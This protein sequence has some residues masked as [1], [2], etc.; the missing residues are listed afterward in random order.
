MTSPLDYASIRERLQYWVDKFDALEIMTP[1]AEQMW[2]TAID[3]IKAL[4]P[5]SDVAE[6]QKIA[7]ELRKKFGKTVTPYTDWGSNV[8]LSSNNPIVHKAADMLERLQSWNASMHRENHKLLDDKLWA[9]SRVKSAEAKV[10]LLTEKLE[11]TEGA[12]RD[13][14]FHH[15]AWD[16][17]DFTDCY[18]EHRP[19]IERLKDKNRV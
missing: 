13:W 7:D 8:T 9:N 1:E 15:D 17:A 6:V 12:L 11:Q 2:Q 18:P 16:I 3:A 10:K 5:P 19:V 4:S 14:L